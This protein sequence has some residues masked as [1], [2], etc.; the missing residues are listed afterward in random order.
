MRIR[1]DDRLPTLA[2]YRE[3][4]EVTKRIADSRRLRAT[5][6]GYDRLRAMADELITHHDRVKTGNEFHDLLSEIVQSVRQMASG[7][8]DFDL[9]E[10]LQEEAARV[11]ALGERLKKKGHSYEA[12]KTNSEK[13]DPDRDRW[14]ENLR[15]A[16]TNHPSW[17]AY[18]LAAWGLKYRPDTLPELSLSQLRRYANQICTGFENR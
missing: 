6:A 2:E 1:G 17:G 11:A 16:K 18:R 14:L 13:A 10:Y 15:D 5:A 8:V 7:K 3:F 12:G 9:D 4:A